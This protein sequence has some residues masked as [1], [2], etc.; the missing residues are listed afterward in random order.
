MKPVQI[1]NYNGKIIPFDSYDPQILQRLEQIT[2][3][4]G[5][6]FGFI[7]QA[8]SVDNNVRKLLTNFVQNNG[9]ELYGLAVSIIAGTQFFVTIPESHRRHLAH[10]LHDSAEDIDVT[11]FAD[12]EMMFKMAAPLTATRR[13]DKGRRP[14]SRLLL[15][16]AKNKD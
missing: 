15:S 16:A 14:K 4:Q 11:E 9:C 6:S 7:I 1:R 3:A 12:L 13:L 2:T 10:L 8:T 5:A